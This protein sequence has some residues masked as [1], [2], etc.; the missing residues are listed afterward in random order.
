ML[1]CRTVLTVVCRNLQTFWVSGSCPY[2]KRCCFIHTELP[3]PGAPGAPVSST[4]GA[5]SPPTNDGRARSL[6]TNSDPNDAPVSLL[7]RI[8]AKRN[9]D[10]G[11][12]SAVTPTANTPIDSPNYQFNA[13]PG[14]LRVDTKVVDSVSAASKQNK[15]AYP[16]FA[17]NTIAAISPGPV[18][19]GPDLGRHINLNMLDMNQV[20]STGLC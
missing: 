9:Q 15:S 4:E 12:Q 1:Q 17:S 2:G 3:A 20:S 19:A 16:S 11:P 7:A 5:T 6:S 8:S 13:R 14:S 10:S 18:T